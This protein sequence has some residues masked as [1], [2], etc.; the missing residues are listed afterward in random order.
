MNNNYKLGRN[1]NH[2]N[3]ITITGSINLYNYNYNLNNLYWIGAGE[4]QQLAKHYS[5]PLPKC[6]P[7]RSIRTDLEPDLDPEKNRDRDNSDSTEML[8]HYKIFS[9]SETRK[10]DREFISRTNFNA[11]RSKFTLQLFVA[12]LDHFNTGYPSRYFIQKTISPKCTKKQ[13]RLANYF[14]KTDQLFL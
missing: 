10:S 13:V 8:E 11:Q 6:F 12:I 2:F 1:L 9:P 7:T 5:D 3:W 14:I 4:R